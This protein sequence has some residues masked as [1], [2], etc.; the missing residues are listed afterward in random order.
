MSKV[1]Y[2]ISSRSAQKNPPPHKGTHHVL[3]TYDL[4]IQ[5]VPEP[6]KM[7]SAIAEYLPSQGNIP[8]M[9]NKN[10]PHS[11][12]KKEENE[13]HAFQLPTPSEKRTR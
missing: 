5:G 4:T 8:N 2:R 10:T 3:T 6:W 9:T 7:Y 12:G 11:K 1:V 13:D